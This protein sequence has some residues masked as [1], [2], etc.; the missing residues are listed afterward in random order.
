MANNRKLQRQPRYEGGRL[1]AYSGF[2]PDLEDAV[3][4]EMR[5]FKATRSFVIAT[6]V[7][8]ALGVEEQPDYRKPRK[9]EK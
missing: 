6:C 2:I 3:Q 5:R 8:F 7:S 4:K 9:G 1:P